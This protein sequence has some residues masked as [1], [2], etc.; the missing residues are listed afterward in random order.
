MI[1][2]HI[3]DRESFAREST[4]QTMQENMFLKHGDTVL[5][6]LGD[7]GYSF[8]NIVTDPNVIELNNGL[9]AVL[10]K[11]K[12]RYDK[13]EIDRIVAN[14]NDKIENSEENNQIHNQLQQ[15]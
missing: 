7:G 14:L 13:E 10:E 5:V 15:T 8:Y 4:V 3:T 11:D 12:R 6:A 2:Q 1:D 9:F